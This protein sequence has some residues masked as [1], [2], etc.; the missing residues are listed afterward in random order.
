MW[1][2]SLQW[3]LSISLVLGITLLWMLA[4][5]ITARNMRHEMDEVFDSALEETA[6]RILPL[7]VL[8]IINR[9]EVGLSQRVAALRPHD[10]YFTYLVRDAQGRVLLRSHDAMDVV[11][12]PF[13]RAGFSDTATHRLYFDSA[14]QDTITIAVAEPLTHRQTIA[15]EALTGLAYPLFFLVPLSLLGIWALVRFSMRRVRAFRSEIE[16]RGSGDLAPVPLG[17]LPS[18]IEPLAEAVNTLL[19]RVRRTLEAER[20]FTANSAH[21]LRT[22]VAAA[23][24]QTQRLM[25]ETKDKSAR[26]RAALIEGSLQRLARLSE[27]LMQLAR[28]E[29][30]RLRSDTPV[31]V[32]PVLGLVIAELGTQAA[33]VVVTLPKGPALSSVD[34]DA[35]AILARNLIENA[36]KHGDPAQPVRVILSD[37]GGL[38]VTNA[39]AV[40]PA[41]GLAHL[42]QPFTRG[43]TEADGT[44][45]GLAIA[46]AIAVGSGGTLCLKSP[47]TA[48]KD[49]FEARYRP[50]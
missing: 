6:Q 22:P 39:G 30:G 15:K 48:Q 36:L 40:V 50:A 1:S 4:S 13:E 37:E 20:S 8:D 32:A 46:K 11:F 27:K 24:A 16:A 7:A 26:E 31:D 43:H 29:G 45:L 23:L 2:R 21:E 34:L 17:N 10:E 25:A 14:L 49:G 41:E 9:E 47:A 33:R 42:S 5:A 28:A 44:G 38:T 3:R 18:E 35:F 19:Q 12:P